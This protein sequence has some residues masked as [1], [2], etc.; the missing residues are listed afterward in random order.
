RQSPEA[1]YRMPRNPGQHTAMVE[2]EEACGHAEN[3][4]WQARFAAQE[5]QH[6]FLRNENVVQFEFPAT[7][8]AHP[9][10]A[11]SVED[12]ARLLRRDKSE[13]DGHALGGESGPLAVIHRTICDSPFRMMDSAGPSPTAGQ[14]VA[15]LLSNGAADRSAAAR[16]S[17]IR[18][19]Q[20]VAHL[21]GR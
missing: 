1:G 5:A 7:G 2:A 12:R 18:A 11:P 15:A 13:H 20:D 4:V 16:N 17:A 3:R 21:L 19:P 6:H 9:A 8:R 14:A 10:N